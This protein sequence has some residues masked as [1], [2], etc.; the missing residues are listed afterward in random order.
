MA[1]HLSRVRVTTDR[2]RISRVAHLRSELVREVS[3][4]AS[5]VHLDR[6]LT[7]ARLEKLV[8]VSRIIGRTSELHVGS[9]LENFLSVR[10]P[11]GRVLLGHGCQRMAFE[12]LL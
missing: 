8:H 9:V 10:G 2:R 3:R 7:I 1:G 11:E 5:A 4:Q 6:L 12:L